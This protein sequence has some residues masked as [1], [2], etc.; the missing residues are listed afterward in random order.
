MTLNNFFNIINKDVVTITGGGGK[1]SLMMKLGK[2]LVACGQKHIITTTTKI[3]STDIPENGLLFVDE[4]PLKIVR[5]IKASNAL[6]WMTG[7]KILPGDKLEGFSISCLKQIYDAFD[8][9]VILNEGDGSKRHPYKFYN[10][11]EPVIPSFTTK[12]IHVIGAEVLN[13]SIDEE[14]FH[15]SALYEGKCKVF[16][17][18]ILCKQLSFF[19]R[20]KLKDFSHIPR[21]LFINKVEAENRSNAQIIAEVGKEMFDACF[22]SSLKE[23][24]IEQY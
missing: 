2:E 14:T 7:R 15:R 22:I 17:K 9:I 18:N 5:S 8:E 12:I 1:T 16:D 6:Q 23:G 4:D 3:C 21:F 10:E 24:W 19:V 13:R 20:V 11:Y